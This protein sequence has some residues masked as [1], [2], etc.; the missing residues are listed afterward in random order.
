MN[1]L[2]PI[3]PQYSKLLYPFLNILK[4]RRLTMTV[5]VIHHSEFIIILTFPHFQFPFSDD[6]LGFGAF[7]GTLFFV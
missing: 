4:C 1:G 5:Q 2:I 7:D 6:F 3:E